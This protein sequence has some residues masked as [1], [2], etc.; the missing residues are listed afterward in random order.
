MIRQKNT[1]QK[2]KEGKEK[3]I[4]ETISR[5]IIAEKSTLILQKMQNAVKRIEHTLGR[6]SGFFRSMLLIRPRL[7]DNKYCYQSLTKAKKMTKQTKRTKQ[8]KIS[9]SCSTLD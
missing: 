8:R 3:K 1:K 7:T 9:D 2:E 5:S 4:D 6:S